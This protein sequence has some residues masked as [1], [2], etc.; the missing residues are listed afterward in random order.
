M[1]GMSGAQCLAEDEGAVGHSTH[2]TVLGLGQTGYACISHLAR[3]GVAVTAM[4]TRQHPPALEEVRRAFP[5]VHIVLGEFESRALLASSQLVLSPG[6]SPQ[7][8]EIRAA[9]LSGVEVIGDV[10][11]FARATSTPIIG[12]TGSNGKS[13]VTALVGEMLTASGRNARV[14]GNFGP[15]ALELLEGP[16]PEYFVLELSSFQLELT[17]SFA[18]QVACILNLAPDH[19]DRH[20]SV[21]EYLQAKARI[22]DHAT[23]AVLNADDVRVA[24][25]P[26]SGRRRLTFTTSEPSAGQFGLCQTTDGT[27]LCEGR[28]VLLPASRIGLPGRHNLANCLAA[29]AV[30]RAVGVARAELQAPLVAFAG[31]PHRCERIARVRQVA[32]YNDSKGTNPAAT[33]AAI[34][35]V[36]DGCSGVLIAGGRAKGA[37]FSEL[38]DVIAANVHSVILI[39][40]DAQRLAEAI[41]DRVDTF[42]ATDMRAAVM[43]AA[44]VARSGDSVLLSPAC[45]SFDMFSGFEARG[46]AFRAAV[47]ELR[48]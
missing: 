11:L 15:P 6:V 46:A 33:L 19:L 1:M 45:A 23:T 39:G 44:R 16:E 4:D 47:E 3:R 37:D 30:C 5:D 32:Y 12:I 38:A 25:L 22:L 24:G 26:F 31:L 29:I 9:M 2:C 18:P 17:N 21:D 28:E 10:E 41:S 14:G 13:T 7:R 34:D 48:E 35:G 43:T 20:G 36:F 8:P 27:A 40:E 42:L